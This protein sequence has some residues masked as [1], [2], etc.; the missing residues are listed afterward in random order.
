MINWISVNDCL[1][2]DDRD[3]IFSTGS[4]QVDLYF[5][6]LNTYKGIIGEFINDEDNVVLGVKFWAEKTDI[7]LPEIP[8]NN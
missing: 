8:N 3:I 6:Y 7:N 4:N 5:G 2:D 1:P